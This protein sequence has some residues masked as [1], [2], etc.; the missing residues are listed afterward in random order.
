MAGEHDITTTVAPAQVGGGVFDAYVVDL[1]AAAERHRSW[2]VDAETPT[3]DTAH[4]VSDRL[5]GWLTKVAGR[6][7]PGS[8]AKVH[9]VSALPEGIRPDALYVYLC[10]P[11]KSRFGAQ[12]AEK[13]AA[14]GHSGATM[15]RKHK[16]IGDAVLCEVWPRKVSDAVSPSGLVTILA[17]LIF[18]EWLHFKLDIDPGAEDIVHNLGNFGE[19]TLSNQPPH[20]PSEA[21]LEPLGKRLH[22]EYKFYR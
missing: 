8:T 2:V 11:A 7:R 16:T 9:W 1:Q 6:A 17:K 20:E 4:E 18:H 3:N 22:Q 19:P 12:M 13:Q 21:V 15:L 14:T 10:A 5:E